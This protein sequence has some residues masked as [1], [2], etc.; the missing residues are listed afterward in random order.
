[1]PT[2]ETTEVAYFDGEFLAQADYADA[3]A[4]QIAMARLGSSALFD[5]G[6]VSGLTVTAAGSAFDVAPGLAIDKKGRLV[7]LDRPR[8]IGGPSGAGVQ[9]LTIAYAEIRLPPLGKGPPYLREDAALEWCAEAALAPD[10][11]IKLVLG[12]RDP[13]APPPGY[14]PLGRRY[15]GAPAGSIR[16]RRPGGDLCSGITGW[17]CGED[18]GLRID[19]PA[20]AVTLVVGAAAGDAPAVLTVSGGSLGVGTLS[21]GALLD[22]QGTNV[23]KSGPGTLTSDHLTVT[24]SSDQLGQLVHIGDV[25]IVRDRAGAVRQATVDDT[26]MVGGVVRLIT[27]TPLD[28]ED[29]PFTYKPLLLVSVRAADRS[30]GGVFVIDRFGQV[31]FGTGFPR[32]RLHVANGDLALDGADSAVRFGGSSGGGGR[33]ATLAGAGNTAVSG[34]DGV[35]A[36]LPDKRRVEFRGGGPIDWR[37][38]G[39]PDPAMTLTAAG[40]VGIGLAAG[41][42]PAATLDVDGAIR[43]TSGGFVFPDGTVQTTAQMSVPIGT[44][45]DWWGGRHNLPVPPAYQ[46]CDGSTVKDVESPLFGEALPN[47]ADCFIIGAKREGWTVSDPIGGDDHTHTYAAPAHTHGM[48]H[49]HGVAAPPG[50]RRRRPEGRRRRG[51]RRSGRRDAHAPGRCRRSDGRRA[52][53]R[54]HRAEFRRIERRNG[55]GLPRAALCRADEADAHQMKGTAMTDARKR[56]CYLDGA[57]LLAR[58]FADEQA[59]LAGVQTLRNGAPHTWGIADGLEV[60]PVPGR[61]AVTVTPGMAIDARGRQIVLDRPAVFDLTKAGRPLAAFLTLAMV[62]GVA[63]WRPFSRGGG[64]TRRVETPVL[65]LAG[66]RPDGGARIALAKLAVT[67]SG[68]LQPPDLSMRRYCGLR[69]GRIVF[70]RPDVP[71][72]QRPRIGMAGGG[73]AELSVTAQRTNV[74]GSTRIDGRVVVGAETPDEPALLTVRPEALSPGAGSI[75]VA[76]GVGVGSSARAMAALRPGDVLQVAGQRLMVAETLGR[77]TLAL[78][79]ESPAARSSRYTNERF[80]ADPNV[81]A[82]V[83]TGD[84]ADALCIK[85]VGVVGL[86]REPD[87]TAGGLVVGNGDIRRSPARHRRRPTRPPPSQAI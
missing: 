86:G 42:E 29:A 16:F 58:D 72:D 18:T 79:A 13:G 45:I 25:L 70:P 50:D 57:L 82:R 9:C 77:R 15:A 87:G 33:I 60:V 8:R 55:P 74:F 30:I 53:P 48:A 31:G 23:A 47:L 80:A 85:N 41:E 11:G 35:V 34:E 54:Q 68:R 32:S 59:Y 62:D 64:W 5:W 75:T 61:L 37:I 27:D 19:A 84:L 1:M 71:D 24:G 26:P 46:V 66:A 78:T 22:V 83:R 39:L 12:T 14:T 6:V 10:V 52:E 73:A 56:P 21:P 4:H 38:G 69:V 28:C 40:R 81:V 44:V 7:L 43:S 67:A 76:D 17:N 49:Q 51:D 2:A 20:T 63:A 65:A 36:F 3:Q